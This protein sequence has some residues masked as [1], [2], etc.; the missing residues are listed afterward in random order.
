[1]TLIKES[2]DD[3]VKTLIKE[4]YDFNLNECYDDEVNE[5]LSLGGRMDFKA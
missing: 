5:V 3:E 1:M 2:Y 4:S